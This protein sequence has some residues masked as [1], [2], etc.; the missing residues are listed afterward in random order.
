MT[1]T[2]TKAYEYNVQEHIEDQ[3]LTDNPFESIFILPDGSMIFGDYCD[4]MRG[5]DHQSIFYYFGINIY[6]N[7]NVPDNPWKTIHEVAGVMRVVG[8]AGY[9]LIYKGQELTD[10]QQEIADEYGLIVEEYI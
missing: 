7:I 1:T 6:A 9:A 8:E 10:E 3:G 2:Q 5:T 4:G